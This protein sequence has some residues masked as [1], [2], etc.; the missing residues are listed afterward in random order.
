MRYLLQR[1]NGQVAI[2]TMV[3]QAVK[4]DAD[5]LAIK[6]KI[7]GIQ[8]GQMVL[9]NGT[10]IPIPNNDV[11]GLKSDSIAGMTLFFTK[12]ENDIAK[13]PDGGDV[14]VI[15][16]IEPNETLPDRAFRRAWG[17]DLKIDMVKARS[18]WKDNIKEA[19]EARLKELSVV[20]AMA[21]MRNDTAPLNR[22][23]AKVQQ[24]DAVENHPGIDS[25]ST[26]DELKTI[27]PAILDAS[28]KT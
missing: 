12:P 25:A 22:I 23:N 28:E 21:A 19:K 17:A 8:N 1:G 27:W 10:R 26:P 11:A 9:I 20:H 24:L 2:M 5:P 16:E 3:P 4:V 6:I 18:I 7:L 15:R 13:W 14:T